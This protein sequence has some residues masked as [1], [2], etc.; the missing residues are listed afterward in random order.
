[1][2][3]TFA[4]GFLVTVVVIIFVAVMCWYRQKR[5]N[6]VPGNSNHWKLTYCTFI[7]DVHT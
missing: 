7:S 4:L 2:I 1:M 6:L 5:G 3:L